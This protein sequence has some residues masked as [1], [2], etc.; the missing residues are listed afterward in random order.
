VKL[1][2]VGPT[3]PFRGGSSQYTTLL[4][5]AL[6]KRHDVFFASYS[7]QYFRWMY[8][9][10][11]DQDPSTLTVY[12]EPDFLFDAV[13]PRAWRRLADTVSCRS[14]DHVLLPWTVTYWAPFFY[15]FLRRL[16]VSPRPP[17]TVF[18]CHNIV[19]HE[20]SALKKSISRRVLGLAD[21]FITHSREDAIHL[22]ALLGLSDSA[23]IRTSPH[24]E[25][26]H[27]NVRQVD[28]ASARAKLGVEAERVLLFF[29]FVRSYKG[30]EV[31]A[32]A[33]SLVLRELPVHL[34]VAGEFWGGPR[35]FLERLRKL[36]IESHVTT[37]PRFIANEDVPEY[38]AACDVVVIPYHSATQSGI[39][40]MAY[41]FDRPVVATRVG[42]LPEMIRD[43]E[44]GTLVP[45]GDPAALAAGIVDFFKEDRRP[46]MRAAIRDVREQFSWD[47]M[48]ETIEACAAAPEA[49]ATAAEDRGRT[50]LQPEA[51]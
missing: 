34:V 46:S 13:S 7:R 26:R 32:D 16:A 5:R 6:R 36:G 49:E 21:A 35:R 14:P 2:V 51:R 31:L 24:P 39:V 3:H 28:Q 4:V 41:G 1:A 12:E 38:F 47:R 44:T 50:D 33:L 45:P 22:R 23:R 37:V 15:L 20:E 42:G 19:E 43:G 25:Y 40:Q 18:L 27:L 17:R 48:V 10:S 8:P 29:G 30:L 11:T 9:G